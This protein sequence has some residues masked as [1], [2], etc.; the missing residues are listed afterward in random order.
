MLSY[1]FQ[2]IL[3]DRHGWMLTFH[4][5]LLIFRSNLKFINYIILVFLFVWMEIKY[6]NTIFLAAAVQWSLCG[7]TAA[8]TCTCAS[9]RTGSSR[10]SN[11]KSQTT[12]SFW[13][14]TLNSCPEDVNSGSNLFYFESYLSIWFDFEKH[15]WLI[16]S[17]PRK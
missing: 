13:K 11:W 14:P 10:L 7:T 12:K 16:P 17:S 2:L 1:R 9:C 5:H 6:W 8:K 15:T 4:L 3:Y